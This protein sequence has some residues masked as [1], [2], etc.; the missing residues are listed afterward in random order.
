MPATFEGFGLKLLYPDNWT[1]VERAEDEGDQGATFDL[2]GGGFVS[3]E[4]LPI[5]REDEV[6]LGEIDQMLR[7]QYEDL[8]RDNVTLPGASEGER[9]VDLRFYYLDLV[10]MSRVVLLDAPAPTREQMPIA[11]RILAQLQAEMSDFEAAE[12]VFNA[13]LQQIRMAELPEEA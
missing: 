9:A 3:L 4:T 12:Q 13:I 6:V 2:P 11:G 5:T 1:L 10:V 8:E 7:G